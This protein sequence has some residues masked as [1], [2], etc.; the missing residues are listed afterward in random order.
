[1]RNGGIMKNS[2]FKELNEYISSEG[3]SIGNY[4]DTLLALADFTPDHGMSE[5]LH[6]EIEEEL[7]R[8]LK[9]FRDNYQFIE[10]TVP[11]PDIVYKTL[12]YLG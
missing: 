6:L 2:D 3:T 7:Q 10:K 4:L 11:Q 9:E 12:E 5:K 8:W 1:M